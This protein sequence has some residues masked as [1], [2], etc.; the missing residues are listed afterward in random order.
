MQGEYEFNKEGEMVAINT[1]KLEAQSS[2]IK[3]IIKRLFSGSKLMSISLP[4]AA[5]NQ[6]SNLSLLISSYRH[7][8]VELEAAAK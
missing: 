1:Q 5:F 2:V 3:Y 6:E 4:V 7:A 8:P